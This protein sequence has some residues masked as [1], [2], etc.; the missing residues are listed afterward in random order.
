[1]FNWNAPIPNM[2]IVVII[3][4]VWEGFWKSIG[5]WKAAKRNETAWFI[6]VFVINFFG[7]IPIVYLWKTKQ[8][9]PALKDIQNFFTSKLKQR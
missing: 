6:A 5:L 3:L 9:E 7:I 2:N 4:I 8:L 1:M